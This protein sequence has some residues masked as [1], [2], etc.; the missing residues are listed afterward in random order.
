LNGRLKAWGDG[1][2]ARRLVQFANVE[3]TPN[4]GGLAGVLAKLRSLF[5]PA[6]YHYWGAQRAA[7]YSPDVTGKITEQLVRG[8]R[9]SK[10]PFFIWWAPAAPHREDVSVTLM[11][12]PGDDPRPAPRYARRSA[13]FTLPMGPS[14]NE[15]D[16]SDKSSNLRSHAPSL[17][18][19]QIQPLR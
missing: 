2:F 11:G 1:S 4:P 12:R 10:K 5:G 14:F 7:D 6:P 9:R 17:T 16:F 15:A 18:A 3:V 19:A 13:S 8:E